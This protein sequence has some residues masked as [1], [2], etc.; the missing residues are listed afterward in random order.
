MYIAINISHP[1]SKGVPNIPKIETSVEILD[2]ED[3]HLWETGNSKELVQ[4]VSGLYSGWGFLTSQSDRQLK[5][6][7]YA[8]FIIS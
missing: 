7:S 8:V 1:D 2:I 6:S 4:H 5:F 3:G